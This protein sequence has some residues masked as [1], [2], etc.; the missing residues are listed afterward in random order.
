MIV[1]APHI[2]ISFDPGPSGEATWVAH[3]GKK[4]VA[5]AEPILP[6]LGPVPE[7]VAVGVATEV[8]EPVKLIPAP[9]KGVLAPIQEGEVG[10]VVEGAGLSGRVLVCRVGGVRESVVVGKHPCK[11]VKGKVVGVRREG[12]G[13]VVCGRWN[14]F[15]ERVG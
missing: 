6:H 1:P 14:R 5:V 7:P 11:F 4:L 12:S 13:W 3:H 10:A 2:A 8:S 9:R 15:G